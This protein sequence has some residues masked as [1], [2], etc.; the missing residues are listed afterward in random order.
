M[1]GYLLGGP[2]K[3]APAVISEELC[4]RFIRAANLERPAGQSDEAQ[5]VKPLSGVDRVKGLCTVQYIHEDIIDFTSC[6]AM[7]LYKIRA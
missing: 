2:C 1:A 6:Q 5:I 3:G 7:L 4:A